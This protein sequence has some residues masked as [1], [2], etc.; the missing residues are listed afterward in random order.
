M[1]GKEGATFHR[2]RLHATSRT[3]LNSKDCLLRQYFYVAFC[4]NR[5]GNRLRDNREYG[6][7]LLASVNGPTLGR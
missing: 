5:H 1:T 7:L 3:F 4:P 6:I 2:D